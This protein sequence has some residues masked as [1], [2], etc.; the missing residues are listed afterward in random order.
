[1]HV[2]V[3]KGRVCLTF[4][5]SVNVVADVQVQVFDLKVMRGLAYVV[6]TE[7]PGHAGAGISCCGRLL[8]SRLLR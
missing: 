7:Q 3:H 2:F 4:V 5:F 1:M 8:G 6:G